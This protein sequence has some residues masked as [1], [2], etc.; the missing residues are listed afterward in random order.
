[1][2]VVDVGTVVVGVVVVDVGGV[3]GGVNVVDVAGAGIG[4]GVVDGIGVGVAVVLSAKDEPATPVQ[5]SRVALTIK[6][7]GDR[8]E[9]SP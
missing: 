3:L 8:I 4:V 5:A 2:V 7:L 1:V 9:S 6:S